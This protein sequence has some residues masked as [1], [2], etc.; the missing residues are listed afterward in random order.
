MV[1]T[2]H[3][4]TRIDVFNLANYKLL[5]S[6]AV[7]QDVSSDLTGNRFVYV[8]LAVMMQREDSKISTI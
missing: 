6:S 7:C 2:R 4:D 1:E 8:R 5:R 3:R